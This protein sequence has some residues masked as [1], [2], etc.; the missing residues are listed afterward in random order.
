MSEKN[1]QTAI[2]FIEAIFRSDR[3]ATKA[4]LAPG[5][6]AVAKGFGQLS[7]TR[8]YD[9]MIASVDAFKTLFPQGLNPQFKTVTGEGDTVAIEFVGDGVVASGE[10]YCNEY[11]MVFTFQG[12]RIS[13]VNEYYCTILADQRV[14]PILSKLVGGVAKEPA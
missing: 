11:C 3:E 7:G 1:K 6:I 5:A 4:C 12:D 10:P 8:D 2:A 13:Q 9:T 14:L